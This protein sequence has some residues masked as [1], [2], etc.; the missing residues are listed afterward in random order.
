MGNACNGPA[1]TQAKSSEEYAGAPH[2]PASRGDF[3]RPFPGAELDVEL[4]LVGRL[5]A[6]LRWLLD[7]VVA[8]LDGRLARGAKRRAI[9]ANLQRHREGP[10]HAA[11]RKC[12]GYLAGEFIASPGLHGAGR[13]V[14]F[15]LQVRRLPIGGGEDV[16]PHVLIAN[17]H[18]GAEGCYRNGGLHLFQVQP[19]GHA[20]HH[21]VRLE[22]GGFSFDTDPRHS[23][24]HHEGSCAALY[25][26]RRTGIRALANGGKTHDD[27][28]AFPH[29]ILDK[30]VWNRLRA[31]W[32][33][34]CQVL[35][36]NA[37]SMPKG[38]AAN[39]RD[40]HSRSKALKARVRTPAAYLVLERCGRL[41]RDSVP[42]VWRTRPGGS[43]VHELL[44]L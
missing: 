7:A 40:S 30:L 14:G 5:H 37:P 43:L 28:E 3:R 24:V 18:A 32:R 2:R 41:P 9:G 10:R 16:T 31:A 38:P 25:R 22:R 26:C 27:R 39:G 29:S 23:G 21:C 1:N 13:L 35:A 17:R 6:E 34:F 8:E 4:N 20:L 42:P 12:A 44:I 19:L 11:D 36:V 15:K 33:A